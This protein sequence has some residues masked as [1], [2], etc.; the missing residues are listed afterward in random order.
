MYISWH[1]C[2]YNISVAILD[3]WRPVSPGSV[4]DSTIEKFDPENMGV[5][6]GILASLEAEKPLWGSFLT[7]HLQHKRY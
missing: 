1:T 2:N 3:I 5:A 7:S 4:I 6:V